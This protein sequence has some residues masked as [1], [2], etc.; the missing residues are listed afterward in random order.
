MKKIRI[1][2]KKY[3]THYALV[4]DEDFE[5]VFKYTW[6][7]SK[8]VSKTSGNV[9][10]YA[11]TNIRKDTGGRTTLQMHRLILGLDF[12]DKRLVDHINYK[13]LDNRRCNLRTCSPLESVRHRRKVIGTSSNYRGVCYDQKNKN[14]ASHI[15][16]E[17]RLRSLGSFNTQ[18][19]AAIQY[20]EAAFAEFGEFAELN[21]PKTDHSKDDFDIEN[22][23]TPAQKRKSSKFVGVNLYKGTEKWRSQ[24]SVDRKKIHLG[25]FKNEK[26]AAKAYNNYVIKHELNKKLNKGV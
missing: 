21:F 23:K 1:P 11:R 7:L 13:T 12:G 8:K 5:L 16:I 6:H 26:D 24:I 22:Y 19:E 15:T 20:D 4:D 9:F 3:G 2:S 10:F 18:K 25:Y 17:G 14:W